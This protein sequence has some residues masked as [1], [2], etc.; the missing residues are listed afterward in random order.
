MLH[1]R[2]SE[3]KNT[4]PIR[5][6]IGIGTYMI[7]TK[8]EEMTKAQCLVAY[9]TLFHQNEHLRNNV[10]E[11]SFLYDK[12]KEEHEWTVKELETLRRSHPPVYPL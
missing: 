6:N 2:L 8:A 12:I 7:P 11:L 5:A 1:D 3:I 4:R 9:Q 10:A